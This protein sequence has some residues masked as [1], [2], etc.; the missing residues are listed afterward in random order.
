M[1][2]FNEKLFNKDIQNL[3]NL[4]IGI[5][6]KVVQLYNS[7][8]QHYDKNFLENVKRLKALTE[9]YIGLHDYIGNDFW[10]VMGN[11]WTVAE[12]HLPQGMA[13]CRD[14]LDAFE[15]DGATAEFE[16]YQG[17]ENGGW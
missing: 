1:S 14:C 17:V 12:Q 4:E 11:H 10:C 16:Q 8:G 7:V 13:G 6:Q 2:D 3:Q 9:S 15:R 5:T